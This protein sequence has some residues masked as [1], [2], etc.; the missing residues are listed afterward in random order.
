MFQ[1]VSNI[2]FALTWTPVIY[3]VHVILSG[4]EIYNH[5]LPLCDLFHESASTDTIVSDGRMV[6]ELDKI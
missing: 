5:Y 6:D 1:Q 3:T 4:R 2:F